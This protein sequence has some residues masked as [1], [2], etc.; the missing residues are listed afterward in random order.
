MLVNDLLKLGV[1]RGWGMTII[2][3]FNTVLYF[4]YDVD[5]SGLIL[6]AAMVYVL[7]IELIVYRMVVRARTNAVF[8]EHAQA[9][10]T[11]A[12]GPAERG[13]L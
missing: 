8:G 11:D 9:V 4:A 2:A 10:I 5:I 3:A 6:F 1:I 13:S 12:Y 7:A